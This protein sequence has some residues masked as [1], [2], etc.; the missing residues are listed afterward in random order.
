MEIAEITIFKSLLYLTKGFLLMENYHE[1]VFFSLTLQVE[2][3][4][5]HS[6]LLSTFYITA[7]LER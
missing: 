1:K 7:V 5:L 6:H 2:G 4:N 3:Q